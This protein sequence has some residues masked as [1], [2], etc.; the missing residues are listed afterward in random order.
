MIAEEIEKLVEGVENVEKVEVNSSTLRQ[1]DTQIIPST[2]LKPRSN[3]ESPEVEITIEVQPVNINEKEEESTEDDYELKRRDKGK[4]VKE[5][6]ST[7]SPTTINPLGLI[8]LSYL[9]I[10]V[11]ARNLTETF[12]KPSFLNPS[13]M[14]IIQSGIICQLQQD[15]LPIWL[16]L[17][18]KF[19]RLHVAT[20]PYRPS[21]V[22]PR[23]QDDPYDDA[24]LEGENSQ[25]G[26]RRNQE[27]L[28][29]FDFCTDSYATDY[30]EIPNE[31]VS[32]EL[33][34][35]M[36]HT[37]DEAKLHKV[38]DEISGAEKIVMSLHKFPAVIFP[39]DDIEERTSRWVE[40]CVN[41]FNPYARYNVEHW[42]NP[43]AKIF[44]IKK[45]KEPRKPKEIV[46]R[47]A[48][49]SIVSIT[50]S[51]YKNLNKNDIED[52]YLLIVHKVWKAINISSI[53]LNQQSL[54]QANSRPDT[55]PKE[56]GVSL[57][58][59]SLN[60]DYDQ[61]VQNYNMRNIGKSIVEMHVM[62]KLHEKGIPKKV[63]TPA[64]FA[65]A[66]K[67]NISLPPKRH[68][69]AKDSVYHHYKEVG[70]WKRNYP[71]YQAE[72]KKK[73]N[74]SVASTSGIFTI[75]LYAFPNKT[76]VYDT[77]HGTHICN[78]SQG[79][80]GSKKLKHKALSLYMGNG[81]RAA[82]EA[83]RSFDLVLPSGLIIILDNY[84]VF[85]FNAIPRDG[86]YEIDMH[87]LYPNDSSMFNV[88]NKRSKHVLDSSYLWHCH[89]GHINKKCIDTL[90][91][92]RM[93]QPTHNESL[94]KCK[95]V[96]R[97]GASY[98]I[99]FTNDFSRYG[100]V[101][102][103]KH[104]HEVFETFKVFQNEVENQ[105]SKKIKGY[106]LEF[107]ARIL[108]MVLTKKVERTPY[109]IWHGKAPKLSYLRE[110]MGY[111]FYYPLENKIFVARNAKFFENRLMVQE[112][113]GSHG[114]LESSGSDKGLKLFQ[115]KDIQ[116]SKNSSKI[117]NEVTPIEV[118][119]QNVKVPIRRSARIPQSPDRYGFYV[120][121]EEYELGDLNEPPNY[122]AALSNLE[123]DKWL[124]AMNTEMQSMKDNQV[125]ILVD[126]PP[127]GRTVGSKLLFKKKTD[128]DGNVHTFK[129]HLVA[130][131][132]T[133]TYSVDYGENFSPIADIRAIR[134]LLAIAAFY[135][136]EIWQMDVKTSFLNGHLSK[137]V[138][139]EQT[140]RFVDQNIPTK[141]FSMK[142][143][144][145][146]TY[147]L[148]IK[149][150]RDRSKLL[151]ALKQS[152]Y[153][154]KIL[155]RFWM[156]NSKKGYTPM[157]EKRDY[158]KSQGAKTLSKSAKQST[159]AMSS[160]KAEY[161]AA[162]EASME[163]VWMR[164]FIDGL[165]GVVPSNKRPTEMLYDNEPAIAIANPG[166]L[167]GQ[168]FSE[169][170]SL[171]L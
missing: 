118:E 170:I 17:K 152:A 168:K 86:I 96:S 128:M 84:N 44:Y 54:S 135:D 22:R 122:K 106:A 154:E 121:V 156:E 69:L 158:R 108:N 93:L 95:T 21:D 46:A 14:L 55:M 164:K 3:K 112:A 63:E 169:E 92:D 37:V 131:G 75:K 61:F 26:R 100:Y 18:Y 151:V 38:V 71:S 123:F 27:Q 150:I 99:T 41:R 56:L 53:L 68:N 60:K 125:W 58:L 13:I 19:E 102:L 15:D 148:E 144:G 4:H 23:D 133:Q 24:Y 50:E 143:L 83:I 129:A 66:P 97:E 78:T 105:L 104:K 119:P 141:C 171:H 142:D 62:L 28:D 47:R 88:S 139:M 1:D 163:A 67:P 25:R 77:G 5:S 35:E 11:N 76:W 94:E 81:K 98:F 124:E 153:L 33:V 45:Q 145:E 70:H 52:M 9:L 2:R 166:I 79:L 160:T 90:Q 10:T 30:D 32:Q 87:N 165:G 115:E 132:Y 138:Y 130:K 49:G 126:V 48:N 16:A 74:A 72:L 127:N 136:Y 8:P 111:Y 59:N 64:I 157:I 51:D 43:H 167:K 40:K 82:V 161:I 110:K 73:K 113:S 114:L 155:K 116:P 107:A 147:I 7:P 146:T 42:K 101:Y 89:L 159:T 12:P 162:A 103:M 57:I 134:I 6:R 65:Y 31:K 137:D 91:R 36:S 120:D 149:I 85:Y 34:D 29:D 80:R 39:D 109:E 140:L 20:T 117:H